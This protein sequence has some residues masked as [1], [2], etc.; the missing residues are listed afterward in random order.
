VFRERRRL[1]LTVDPHH[2][3]RLEHVAWIIF[4]GFDRYIALGMPPV[5][6]ADLGM[7][8]KVITSSPGQEVEV[9]ARAERRRFSREY[10]RRILRE[11]DR[12]RKPGE[13]GALLRRGGLGPTS[14]LC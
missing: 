13:I 3:R 12:C 5:V 14:G 9:L 6:E 2:E 11:A 8:T 1:Q 10:K 7:E 4:I